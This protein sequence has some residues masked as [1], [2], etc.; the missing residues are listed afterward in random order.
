[1]YVRKVKR[2]CGVRGCRCVDSYAISLTR[3]AGNSVIICKSCLGKALG[4]IDDVDPKTKTNIPKVTR[5]APP[6]FYNTP[7]EETEA[8]QEEQEE[9]ELLES[10]QEVEEIEAP[11][12]YQCPVCGK[13]CKSQLGLQRHLATHK[14]DE[15]A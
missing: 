4:A 5:P 9:T 1:M 12:E 15:D 11:M 3:E 13:V 6:L 14:G 10:M 8:P 2:K 7:L